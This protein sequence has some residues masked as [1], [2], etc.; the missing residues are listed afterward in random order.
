MTCSRSDG[1]STLYPMVMAVHKAFNFPVLHHE[2]LVGGH[3][4]DDCTL[5]GDGGRQIALM[6]LGVHIGQHVPALVFRQDGFK[7]WH[8]RLHGFERLDLP[9]L[10]DPPEEVCITV[11]RGAVKVVS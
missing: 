2:L 8:R 9:A 10:A 11:A 6:E 5:A 3:Y 4:R 1:G 7:G